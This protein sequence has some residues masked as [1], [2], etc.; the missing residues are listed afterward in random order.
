MSHR[1]LHLFAALLAPA[2][3]SCTGT[4]Q[5][6]DE[7][8][9]CPDCPIDEP[10]PDCPSG[11]ATCDGECVDLR[12]DTANCGEC[13]HD[14]GEPS[15]GEMRCDLGSCELTCDAGTL[16]CLGDDCTPCPDNATEVG[17]DGERCVAEACRDGFELCGGTCQRIPDR[18]SWTRCE[19]GGLVV[20]DCEGLH[21]LW[22]NTC[23]CPADRTPTTT[24]E[25]VVVSP[26]PVDEASMTG[27]NGS[28]ERGWDQAEVRFCGEGDWFVRARP[29]NPTAVQ[30]TGIAGMTATCDTSFSGA[31]E[32]W[33]DGD[34]FD[35]SNLPLRDGVC[36]LYQVTFA[37]GE[38]A[39]VA[40]DLYG[41]YKSQ[42][43]DTEIPVGSDLSFRLPSEMVVSTLQFE[44]DA[45]SDPFRFELRVE[46]PSGQRRGYRD[47]VIPAF[48][49]TTDVDLEGYVSSDARFEVTRSKLRVRVTRGYQP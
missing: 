46:L 10:D 7:D 4:P 47:L 40:F 16:P 43:I 28:G 20:L 41:P 11:E 29:T 6:P 8:T 25:T 5:S 36:G 18:A 35:L 12:T 45:N 34:D 37:R 33:T 48:L 22:E 14:C 27:C 2:L 1:V 39:D 15:R 44:R 30:R 49:S 26:I 19:D 24:S 32:P 17:C 13:G 21:Y 42:R 9:D 3:L 38:G 23:T 31:C